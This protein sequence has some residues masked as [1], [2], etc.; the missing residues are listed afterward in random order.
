LPP[1]SQAVETDP[2]ERIAALILP[3]ETVT[4]AGNGHAV[5]RG[6]LIAAADEKAAGE[7]WRNWMKANIRA[8]LRLILAEVAAKQLIRRDYD[9]DEAVNLLISPAW[10]NLIVMRAPLKEGFSRDQAGHLIQLLKP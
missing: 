8:P 2:V 6:A 3:I 7:S 1:V 10:H 5:L 4:R 9:I